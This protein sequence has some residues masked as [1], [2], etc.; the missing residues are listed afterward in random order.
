MNV[1]ITSPSLEEEEN[2]S[3]I[4]SVVKLLMK[5]G[6]CN[7]LHFTLG[8]KDG[9]SKNILSWCLDML[10]TFIR[11]NLFVKNNEI[12]VLHLNVPCDV[13]GILREYI[14]SAIA[15]SHNKKIL[16]HLHGGKLLLSSP[17]FI[18][19]RLFRKILLRG[20]VVIVLSELEKKFIDRNYTVDNVLVV[21]NGME[22]DETASV[23]KKMQKYP[24]LL[25]LGRIEESKGVEDLV[26]ALSKLYKEFQ[27]KFVLCGSGS[28]AAYCIEK[29][30][31]LMK[32]DFLFRGV[33]KGADKDKVIEES[34]IFVLP[35]RYGEGLPM[36]LLETM[37]K[38]VVPIVTDDASMKVIIKNGHNGYFVEKYN[39]ED[40]YE[41]VAL[42]FQNRNLY[43]EVSINARATIIDSY[44]IKKTVLAMSDIYAAIIR[45]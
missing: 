10:R 14:T 26:E 44:N 21:P 39:S 18:I 30:S 3:G 25:F 41:K 15:K 32:D 13:K 29:L 7:Y 12:D 36:A 20:D 45:E 34:D 22:I 17:N 6:D 24:V 2:V 16:V 11:F 40:I 31:P 35:S 38:G 9:Q 43:D 8:R 5:Y 27:F 23:D 1:L 37:A 28:L 4:S 42:L 33:V 19:K